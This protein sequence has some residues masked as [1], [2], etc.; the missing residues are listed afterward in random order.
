MDASSMCDIHDFT[1]D[2]T[3]TDASSVQGHRRQRWLLCIGCGSPNSTLAQLCAIC[4]QS[5]VPSTATDTRK[6]SLDPSWHA[7]SERPA[8]TNL[9]H[10]NDG[11]DVNVNVPL[12]QGACLDTPGYINNF[13]YGVD[14]NEKY[15]DKVFNKHINAHGSQIGTKWEKERPSSRVSMLFRH[16]HAWKQIHVRSRRRIHLGRICRRQN[17]RDLRQSF[18]RWHKR[19]TSRKWGEAALRRLCN[20]VESRAT[21]RINHAFVRW[22]QETRVLHVLHNCLEVSSS[23]HSGG[24]LVLK[25]LVWTSW[26]AWLSQRR[27]TRA[28]Q[29]VGL[30]Y[31]GRW[32]PRIQHGSLRACLQ[33]WQTVVEADK[34]T[35]KLRRRV[36][37]RGL[38]LLTT[39]GVLRPA[40]GKWKRRWSAQAQAVAILSQCDSRIVSRQTERLKLKDAFLRV[41]CG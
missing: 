7:S 17:T 40:F 19:S 28:M 16:L 39:N 18:N 27:Q 33:R 30:R 13:G 24:K 35:G 37:S 9:G 22:K 23:T 15:P 10:S 21:Q 36:L 34:A 41:S 25:R 1:S 20:I 26:V 8:F 3:S 31:L 14:E 4:S 6:R 32:L 2:Y 12:N 5:L 38:S 11:S 29:S